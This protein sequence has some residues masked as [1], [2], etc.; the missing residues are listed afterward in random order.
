MKQIL[1]LALSALLL[2]AGAA[3]AADPIKVKLWPN[4]APTKNGHEG[5]P[6]VWEDAHAMK[7]SDPEL[8]IYPAKKPNGQCVILAPG[9]GYRFLSTV[10]EGTSFANWFNT[11]GITL[12]V[13]KYRLPNGHSEVPIEDGRRAIQIM[14]ENAKKYNYSPDKV[15]IMGGSAGGHF[16]AT[17]ATM[18][19]EPQ[20]RPDF[21]ILLY[22]VISMTDITHAGSRT[23]LLGKNPS[24]TDIEKYSLENRVNAQ[25]PPAFIVLSTDDKTVDPLN[26]LYYVESLQKNHVPYSLHVYP[27]GGHGFGWKDTMPY[28]AEWGTELSRWLRDLNK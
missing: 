26:S 5:T 6:E 8:W 18:Y 10:N 28:K 25:T 7:V 3:N 13:L 19:G 21:Q 16:A 24:K 14:R 1:S 17:L 20:Y 11:Q 23:H 15:G 27:V 9:G 12:A 4:G 22:P 2:G